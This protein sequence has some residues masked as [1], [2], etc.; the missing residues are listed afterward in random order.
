VLKNHKI[1][2]KKGKMMSNNIFS[3]LGAAVASVLAI[4]PSGGFDSGLLGFSGP[5]VSRSGPPQGGRGTALAKRNA[6]KKKRIKQLRSR[7]KN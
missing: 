6:K 2:T 4:R 5:L 3:R 1:S 7:R